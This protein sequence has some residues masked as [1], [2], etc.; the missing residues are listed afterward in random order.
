MENTMIKHVWSK[1]ATTMI[2]KNDRYIFGHIYHKWTLWLQEPLKM[3]WQNC[4]EAKVKGQGHLIQ[5]HLKG[6]IKVYMHIKFK[7]DIETLRH[8]DIETDSV[9]GKLRFQ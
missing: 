3:V 1:E 2:G 6:L 9:Q 5:P 7:V 4:T 8:W